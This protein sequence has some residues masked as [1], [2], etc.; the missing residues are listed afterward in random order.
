MKKIPIRQLTAHREPAAI[1]K[2]K[3]RRIEDILDGQ[4]LQHDLHRHDFYFLLVLKKGRGTH[5]VDFTPYILQDNSVSFLR[6]GQVHEL[7][8]KA[9]CEGFLIEFNEGFYHPDTATARQRLRKAS[10]KN[11]CVLPTDRFSFMV[12]TLE[13]LFHEYSSKEEGHLDAIRSCLDILF[14]EYVRQSPNPREIS[15]KTNPYSQERLEEFLELMDRHITT[16]KQVSEYAQ[17][18]NLSLYQLNQVT[19]SAVNKTA[20]DLINEHILLEAKRQLLATSNQVKDIADQLGYEDVSYFI[21]FF[22]KNTGL[23][24]DG[25]RQQSA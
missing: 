4:D 18:M 24:P 12:S 3:V 14:I 20:S 19:K 10:N 1:G 5:H 15:T 8:L 6:P 22:K 21:R 16:S 7:E 9:G 17:L 23:T 2:F 13:L 25:F 11:Y